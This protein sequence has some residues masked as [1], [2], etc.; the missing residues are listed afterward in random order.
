[1]YQTSPEVASGSIP[2]AIP[3]SCIP[4]P[5]HMY[6]C[7]CCLL[8]TRAP[9][10]PPPILTLP[11]L[12]AP[13]LGGGVAVPCS[14]PLLAP[15]T[16]GLR[17]I[18][19]PAPPHSPHLSGLAALRGERGRRFHYL[20]GG[21]MSCEQPPKLTALSHLYRLRDKCCYFWSPCRD[22]AFSEISE[23]RGRP[24]HPLPC[25]RRPAPQIWHDPGQAP[26]DAQPACEIPP[27]PCPD[28]TL[29]ALK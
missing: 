25:Q 13:L 29:P 18:T 9:G 6:S 7:P 16:G 8:F 21:H 22:H 17:F 19:I 10:G 4:D 14:C 28:L 12:S 11:C 2:G 26:N 3:W 15:E 1:M 24:S 20:A 27:M 23:S 5:C